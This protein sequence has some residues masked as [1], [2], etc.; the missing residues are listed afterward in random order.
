MT[1]VTTEICPNCDAPMQIVRERREVPLGQRRVT[2]DDEFMRCE[3]CGEQ[4]HTLEQA[5]V[6]HERAIAQARQEDTLLTPHQ[7]CGIREGLGLSRPQFE[8][9]LGVGEKTC[10]RWEKGRVCQN[11][12]TDRLIRLIAANRA[13]AAILAGINGVTLPDSCFVPDVSQPHQP[14]GWWG[15]L[16]PPYQLNVEQAVQVGG[17]SEIGELSTKEHEIIVQTMKVNISTQPLDDRALVFRTNP[18]RTLP[19]LGVLRGQ[20]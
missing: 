19:P 17:T 15:S 18:E 7:I 9:L 11:F 2:V 14:F 4:F 6:R 20:S 8:R 12:A 10:I 5:E 13:N 3:T 1:T 16:S